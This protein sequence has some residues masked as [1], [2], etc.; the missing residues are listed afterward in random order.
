MT[1][2]S[3]RINPT[4]TS[5]RNASLSRRTSRIVE[6]SAPPS[7]NVS[8]SLDR[9][10][11]GRSAIEEIDVSRNRLIRASSARYRTRLIRTD[12]CERRKLSFD[13]RLQR[14]ESFSRTARDDNSHK[15]RYANA[16]TNIY[17]FWHGWSHTEQIAE[18]R[19]RAKT[20]TGRR[21]RK[22]EKDRV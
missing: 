14:E 5:R 2:R 1:E 21:S 10:S 22:E 12:Q 11:T 6:R 9:W 4:R 3:C 7:K 20:I 13:R 16:S 8:S 17:E 18:Y 19:S 15:A